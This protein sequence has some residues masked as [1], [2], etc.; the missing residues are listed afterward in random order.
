MQLFGSLLNHDQFRMGGWV[1][2]PFPLIV[3]S[4]DDGIFM[5]KNGADWYFAE[6]KGQLGLFDGRLHKIRISVV[7]AG[8]DRFLGFPCSSLTGNQGLG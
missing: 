3:P 4:S 8:H 5:D 1:L 6:G 2:L 7:V